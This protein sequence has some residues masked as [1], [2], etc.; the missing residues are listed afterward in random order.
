MDSSALLRLISTLHYSNINLDSIMTPFSEQKIPNKDVVIQ[1][2]LD[3]DKTDESEIVLIIKPKEKCLGFF[4]ASQSV[5]SHLTKWTPKSKLVDY[6]VLAP[7]SEHEIVI[8][9]NKGVGIVYIEEIRTYIKL[10]YKKRKIFP[11]DF[12][13]AEKY[14]VKN[15]LWRD[16][17][18]GY[19][20]LY[21]KNIAK[22]ECYTITEKSGI[23]EHLK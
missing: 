8:Y 18:L 17:D 11:A 22:N 12:A 15:R 23:C 6:E 10:I 5:Y 9:K 2:S 13:S 20:I 14:E 1:L 19:E 4:D 7:G 21:I 16:L 3:T